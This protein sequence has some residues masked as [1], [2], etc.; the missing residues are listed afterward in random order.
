MAAG[1]DA[2]SVTSPTTVPA[3]AASRAAADE[4]FRTRQVTSSRLANNDWT[5]WEPI[6]PVAPVTRTLVMIPEFRC[7]FHR[8]QRVGTIP[9]PGL[10]SG[11]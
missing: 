5:R 4:A 6:N 2:P 8:K 7:R 3:P 10:T 11:S 9:A 1:S